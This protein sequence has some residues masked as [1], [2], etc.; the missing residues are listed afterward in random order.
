MMEL[1][2]KDL[3]IMIEEMKKNNAEK[4][5]LDVSIDSCGYSVESIDF[6]IWGKW[7]ICKNSIDKKRLICYN[8]YSK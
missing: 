6:D 3:T 4:L 8:D 7:R 2:L 5:H 1:T